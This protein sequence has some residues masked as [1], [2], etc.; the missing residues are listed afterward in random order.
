MLSKIVCCRS[1]NFASRNKFDNSQENRQI[2]WNIRQSFC[3]HWCIWAADMR[4]LTLFLFSMVVVS[5]FAHV[6]VVVIIIMDKFSLFFLRRSNGNNHAFCEFEC[7]RRIRVFREEKRIVDDDDCGRCRLK[8]VNK[9]QNEKDDKKFDL[10]STYFSSILLILP[11]SSYKFSRLCALGCVVLWY[12]MV[13][14][15]SYFACH[16]FLFHYVQMCCVQIYIF[17][18]AFFFS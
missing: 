14:R 16:G 7:F 5:A 4:Q 8:C 2:C 12:A 10:K 13:L 17:P 6:N 11:L 15:R 3:M 18:E 9:W 1:I